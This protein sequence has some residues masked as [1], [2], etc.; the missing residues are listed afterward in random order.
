MGGIFLQENGCA[1]CRKRH[2]EFRYFGAKKGICY[3]CLCESRYE[4]AHKLE[5]WDGP[6]FWFDH[7]GTAEE[8]EDKNDGWF[9]S[10]ASLKLFCSRAKLS[11]PDWAYV[12]VRK[13]QKD[14][15]EYCEENYYEEQCECAWGIVS[16]NTTT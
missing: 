2:E 8:H 4:L 9:S 14:L 5:E 16:L 7:S 11:P 1:A 6:V 15:L 3:E 13:W 10:T 12:A